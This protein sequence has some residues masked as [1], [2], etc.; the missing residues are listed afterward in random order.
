MTSK[1]HKLMTAML[2]SGLA[3]VSQSV[4]S[5]TTLTYQGAAFP[6]YQSGAISYAD[7]VGGYPDFSNKGVSVGGFKMLNGNTNQSITAWCVDVFDWLNSASYNNGNKSNLNNVSQ[8]EKLVAQ[9][10]SKVNNATSSAAFQ[11][12]VWEI[13]NETAGSTSFSLS[14]GRFTASGSGLSAAITMANDWLQLNK[15]N[16][17]NYNMAYYIYGDGTMP[18]GVTQNLI[19]MSPVPLPAALPLLLS[20]L[21]IF[22]FALRGKKKES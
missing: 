14:N 16:T 20:G 21:G 7:G 4:F 3:L 11:L 6:S 10:Y 22:G 2:V 9:D 8:L 12:A 15:A 18:N 5:S 17:G 1:T 13:V 19:S